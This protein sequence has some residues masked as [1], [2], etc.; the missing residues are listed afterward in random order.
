[1][2][3]L[4]I[5]GE[6]G[7]GSDRMR[8]AAFHQMPVYGAGFA[9]PEHVIVAANKQLLEML[10][11]FNP[12]GMRL[13]DVMGGAEGQGIV[14]LYD[15]AYA[16]E[17]V[18]GHRSRFAVV[19]PEG[20]E[21]EIF[22]DFDVVPWR[23]VDDQIVGTV[24]CARDVTI[25][26]LR[27]RADSATAA[28][29]TQRFRRARDVIEEVQRVLLPS[30][31]PVLPSLDVAAS[32]VVSGAEQ[33][34]G[35]DWFEVL[36]LADGTVAAVVG[37][38]VGHGVEAS[39]VM[40]QLRAVTLERLHAG[41][42]ATE[43]MEA[44]DR[45]V[46]V[47]PGGRSAT[48]CIL[49]LHPESGEFEYCSAAHPPP[50]IVDPTGESY[51]LDPS[52]EGP[53]GEGGRR[54]AV[55]GVLAMDQVLLM[56]SDG[57]IERPTMSASAGTVELRQ[58]ATDAVAD[59]LMPAFSRARAVDRATT[60]TLE[61]ATRYTGSNDDITLLAIQ[62]CPR[63]NPL[64]VELRT[65]MPYGTRL[66]AAVRN[67]FRPDQA[68][69]HA[70]AHIDEI[71]AELCDNAAQ[72]AYG[73]D[74][75][76]IT[77]DVILRDD[78]VAVASVTDRGRWRPPPQPNT[79]RGL[80]FAIVQHLSLRTTVDTDESGTTVTTEFRPWKQSHS[81]TSSPPTQPNELFDVYIEQRP[82]QTILTVRGPLDANGLTEFDSQL[83][84]CTA[85][86]TPDL[87]IDLD[88]VT[89]LSSAAIHTIR[90]ALQRA[91]TAG[92]GVRINCAPGTIAHQVL[93]L[94]AIPTG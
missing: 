34:A 78:G 90:Q 64:H 62:R 79:G 69:H 46:E 91:D 11:G 14:E 84:L 49:E 31:L 82:E 24:V 43:T 25:E 68:D 57:I 60:Q 38:V 8:S 36:P 35:G 54:R 70:L 9:G 94:A 52:G 23:G 65:D 32:Y 66:R 18:R 67:W 93:T 83:A 17:V 22:I 85:P 2:N 73:S 4:E 59:R 26:V 61:R 27:E 53:L 28:E 86:G 1:M 29:L 77:V 81:S 88:Q 72:H 44:L 7:F 39:A 56:Y 89:L 21:Q 10:D 12:L 37:D 71:V 16:G 74:G 50:L 5:G 87:T 48:V 51:Y 55:R 20:Y 19:T 30:Q 15:R 40:S 76:P 63:L 45:F 33:A 92:I 41:A 75:G 47:A 3:E 6:V 58:Y 80:G 13:A 42:T